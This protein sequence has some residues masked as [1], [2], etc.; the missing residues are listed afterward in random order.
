MTEPE[1][2]Y[3]YVKGQGWVL[4]PTV[5]CSPDFA[6]EGKM[7]RL[8][9]RRPNVG[10][11]WDAAGKEQR[12]WDSVDNCPNWDNWLESDSLNSIFTSKPLRK[13]ERFDDWSYWVV[14]VSIHTDADSSQ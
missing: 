4:G 7:Y 9:H 8:E 13:G 12:W 14:L 2:N 6:W 10:E 11:L 3:N 5:N 1:P